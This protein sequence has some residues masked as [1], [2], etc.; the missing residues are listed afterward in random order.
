MRGS[1][2][3]GSPLTARGTESG[4]SWPECANVTMRGA[5]GSNALCAIHLVP[6]YGDWGLGHA[7]LEADQDARGSMVALWYWYNYHRDAR[8]ILVA[9]GRQ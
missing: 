1:W 6:R 4:A 5:V 9:M 3:R 2:W 7:G 8:G